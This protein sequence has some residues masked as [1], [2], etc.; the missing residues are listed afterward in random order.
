MTHRTRT[1]I[2]LIPLETL[3]GNPDRIAPSL[4]PDGRRLTYVA[5]L[6]GVL[7]VFLHERGGGQDR[8]LTRDRGRGIRR[9]GWAWDG[10]HV[11]YLQDRDGDENWRLFAIDAGT[12]DE[13]LLT[14][15]APD[16]AHPVQVQIL[17]SS[18]RHPST[19]LVGL[20]RR[21]ERVH[22][23]YRLGL[24]DGRLEEIERGDPTVIGWLA[25]HELVV[26]GRLRS[27]P[28]GGTTLLMRDAPGAPW[29]E[30]IRWSAED[31]PLS[32]P[33]R[34]TEDNRR[35]WMRDSRDRNAAALVLFD[36][37]TGET[38]EIAS[39]P[40]Y[41]VSATAFHPTRHEIQA[42]AF[43]RAR[44]EWRVLDE[45]VRSDFEHL[46][47]ADAGELSLVDR[48]L[49]D[50][51]WLVAWTRDD[52]PVAY[53]LW[54][55]EAARVEH[56]FVHREALVGLPLARMEPV[57]IDA[58]DGLSL[59]AYLTRPPFGEAPWPLVL[60]VH[61]GPWVRDTWGYDPEAQWLANRGY[62]CLQ[63]NYRGSTGYGKA[64][65]AA[66]DREW[67]GRMQDD[68]T[69]AVM[70]A[71]QQGIADPERVAIWGGSY[72]GYAALAGVTFTPGVYR[73]GVSIVGPSNLLTFLDSV[74]PYWESF[75]AMLDR[76]VGRLPR[77][78]DGERA[79]QV[80]LEADLTDE[81]RRE[82]EFLRARSPLFHAD[83]V[84]CPMLIAQGANDPRVKKAE[85][86]QFVAAMRE[87][88]L[89]IEYVVYEDEGHGFARP[90]NRLDFYR[91]AERF[92]AR[93][94]GGRC[95][96]GT[97]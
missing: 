13:R 48:S 45:A 16:Q 39:D 80:K 10:R 66:G 3:F 37:A 93:H 25:D 91:R 2:P 33:L 86:D 18:P 82:L 6:D 14:P 57:T 36:P 87:R 52:G 75:R 64:F 22:D 46:L 70:W 15:D 47:A 97:G 34:F 53:A 7:N 89:E 21:D 42:V 17:A 73:C 30:A 41:D 76:R 51:L 29:R 28:D 96:E 88:G 90:E 58:R 19:L 55:R 38:T 24:T 68:L 31:A 5:P 84:R 9:Q 94:L 92:L 74:P 62:A 27:E 49:D 54:D 60:V 61:G 32:G 1:S 78:T 72:G 79:G 83:R 71:V 59:H 26:R 12:G 43:T 95:E 67:G 8:P 65:L 20:N 56:L 50:R 69:D 63:V 4:A 35:L 40:E 44:R 23:V 81:D 77:Y 11:L 85:S